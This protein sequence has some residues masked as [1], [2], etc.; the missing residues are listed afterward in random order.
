MSNRRQ[1]FDRRNCSKPH[2][3][4]NIY[5]VN[6]NPTNDRVYNWKYFFPFYIFIRRTETM[7]N[8]LERFSQAVQENNIFRIQSLM[9]IY[10]YKTSQVKFNPLDV[11]IKLRNLGAVKLITEL[12][13][14][15]LVRSTKTNLITSAILHN[16]NVTNL[17]GLITLLDVVPKDEVLFAA[18]W[19][20]KCELLSFFIEECKL[21]PKVKD[22]FGESPL[23]LARR[24]KRVKCINYL[25]N[26]K[27]TEDN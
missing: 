9:H 14:I 7:T 16:W 21:S 3:Q 24:L 18:V 20:G 19:K 6:R 2:F 17:R 4:H 15:T 11:A 5:F 12:D 22:L 13:P 23:G 8:F 1:F 27:N 10:I 26:M 25:K